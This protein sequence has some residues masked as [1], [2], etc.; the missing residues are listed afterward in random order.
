[1]VPADNATLIAAHLSGDVRAFDQLFRRYSS[2]LHNF[3]YRI[4]GDR[5]RAEDLVQEAFLRVHRHLHR[6]DQ[7]RQFSTWIYTIASNLAKNELRNR[8][9]TPL[10]FYQSSGLEYEDSPALQIEDPANRPEDLYRRRCIAVAV[11]ESV[12]HLS[13]RHREVFVLRELEGKSYEEIATITGCNL[14]TVKSRLNRAR[15]SFAIDIRP[16]LE[17]TAS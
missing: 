14:G 17:R 2:R 4:I 6:F 16:M 15:Q 13:E 3:I 5:E 12:A 11:T 8:G 1:M 9:R 7:S 10:F